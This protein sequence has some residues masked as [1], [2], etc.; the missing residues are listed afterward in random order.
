MATGLA[1][2]Y[3]IENRDVAHFSIPIDVQ[4]SVPVKSRETEHKIPNMTSDIPSSPTVP[5][6]EFLEQAAKILNQGRRIV[7]FCGAGALSAS[8]EVLE[9][10]RKLKAPIVKTLLGNATVPDDDPNCLG[11][12]GLLGTAPSQDAMGSADTLVLIGTSF[13]F[14]DYLP[15]PGQAKAIQID[16]KAEHIGTRYPVLLG[17]TGDAKATL[18]E[19][20]RL[21]E[22]TSD[23]TFLKDKQK[24]L[25]DWWSLMQERATR[26]RKPLKP[27]SIAWELS[28]LLD[29]DAIICTDSGTIT[30]WAARYIRVKKDQ[31]FSCSGTLASMANGLPYAI[32][33]QVAFPNRQV[34]A[35]VGDGGF[36]MLMCE[37]ATA[38]LY[39][40][41]IKIVVIKNVALDQIRWE[42]IGFLGN[43]QYGVEFQDIDFVK[44]AE[45]CGGKG[46]RI[47]SYDRIRPTL[48]A[49]FALKQP[50]II[51]AIVDPN[52]PP[53]PPKMEPKFV[54]NFAKALVKGEPQGGRIALTLF[55]DK[56][57]EIS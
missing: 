46:F 48:S 28:Q 14:A 50:T 45:A 33:A 44:F 34:V 4:V 36:A 30:T 13:P 47:E 41:P 17:L 1:C 38:V 55:R 5:S 18:S 24:R 10:A 19:L 22:D 39:N 49:A 43:P 21:V 27:Q 20:N 11:G 8:G 37:F 12:L 26:K 53:Y 35:F 9:L 56:I 52:E 7:I 16:A 57:D 6:R 2:K 54:E 32:G 42:Q 3:A 23:D 40:L 29:D 31:L 15:R 25:K 51:K